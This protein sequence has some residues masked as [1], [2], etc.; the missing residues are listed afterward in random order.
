MATSRRS[1]PARSDEEEFKFYM[2]CQKKHFLPNYA[3]SPSIGRGI[4]NMSGS[5]RSG[6]F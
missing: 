2:F 6:F 1:L 3:L 4:V 5:E